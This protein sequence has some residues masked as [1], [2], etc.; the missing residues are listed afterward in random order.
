M[1]EI[2]ISRNEAGQ[3]FDKYLKKYLPEA[4]SGFL[5]KM[6]RKKNI[7]L[8]GNKASGREKLEEGDRIKLFLAEDTIG[9]FTGRPQK[10]ESYPYNK[11][12][13]IVCEEKDILVINKPAGMLSQKAEEKDCS[14]V[15]YVI[16]YLIQSGQ[17]EEKE[18]RT[19]KPSVCNRLDRNTSGLIIAGKSLAGLQV[20][21]EH[22]RLRTMAK[23]YLCLVKGK[24]SKSAYIQGY[25]MK[26]KKT[27]RVKVIQVSEKSK[28]DGT[29][30]T[31]IETEYY[32]VAYNDDM[33]LLK[34]HLITGRTHQIRA[35]LSSVGHPVLGD[36]KYG[37]LE[38]NDRF[39]KKYQ[40]TS[41]ML[42]AYE[43]ILP[44]MEEP[45]AYL[46]GRIFT[47]KAPPVFYRVI[48]ETAWQHG[49]Q[50]AFEVQH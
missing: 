45:L 17:L 12:L 13:D 2:V 34:V 14:V 47:A 49:I 23:Y 1:R 4:P 5:Y 20:M 48:K 25:L 33:T 16:G 35:H 7:V 44:E 30:Y 6:M 37:D 50:E 3:R 24:L 32:P 39:R 31:P 28:D 27:N 40:I 29:A 9:K 46:S 8:N 19:F 38:W 22:F 41:Q 36:Y 21:A 10:K 43:L 15:E 11:E 18:L 42:H 26:N